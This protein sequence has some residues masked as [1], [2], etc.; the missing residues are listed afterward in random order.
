MDEVYIFWQKSINIVSCFE[1]LDK[2]GHQRIWGN[3]LLVLQISN[4]ATEYNH[5][6]W[7]YM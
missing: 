5:I 7:Y 6:I 2:S 4:K 1:T 3:V